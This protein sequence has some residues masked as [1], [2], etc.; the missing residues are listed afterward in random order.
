[1]GSGTEEAYHLR[2]STEKGLSVFAS[3]WIYGQQTGERE[4]CA[5]DTETI[6]QNEWVSVEIIA[7]GNE[8]YVR[9]NDRNVLDYKDGLHTYSQGHIALQRSIFLPGDFLCR[10]FEIQELD[11]ATTEPLPKKKV[12]IN[13]KRA[14]PGR[15]LDPKPIVAINT[16]FGIIKVE[17]FPEKAPVTVRNFIEYVQSGFY[18]GLLFHR[19]LPTLVIQ[20]GGLDLNMQ[21]VKTREP[22]QNESAN[23]VSNLRGTIAMAR[24]NDPN[25]AASQFFINLKDNTQFDRVNARDGVG[26]CAFG[27]IIEGMD[28]VEKIASVKTGFSGVHLNVP[29]QAIFIRSANVER[30]MVSSRQPAM[31][32]AQ[33]PSLAPPPKTEK[34]PINE[35]EGFFSLFN[36]KNLNGWKTYPGQPN[37]WRVVG[38]NLVGSGP[39]SHLFSQRGDYEDFHFRV[40]AM[41]NVSGNSGQHFRAVYGPGFIKGYEAQISLGR[42]PVLTGSLYPTGTLKKYRD[43][44]VV[45][46]E[47]PHK[48][49]EWFTQEVIAEGNHIVIK[50]NG[51]TTV[52]FID[53]ER[54]YMQGYLALQQHDPATVV[55][56]RKVEIKELPRT[57][58][59]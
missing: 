37:S 28:V 11:A 47:A 31:P 15:A 21:E 19:V 22:I 56:F 49:D 35:N 32:D 24:T 34:K 30:N 20:G 42:D 17:L 5:A 3:L 53:P 44:L 29:L 58:S 40:E 2:I 41:I 6:H 55:K 52:D 16:S 14:L 57:A 59:K 39:M 43:R 7:L 51:R 10:K 13:D 54:S 45:T 27:H 8:L 36:N 46:G 26:Y 38:G 50:V 25:S 33:K 12:E 18:D 23:D 48:P 4:I 9:L 1:M